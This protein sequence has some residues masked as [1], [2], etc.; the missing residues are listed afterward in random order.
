RRALAD[1]GV[2]LDVA[3]GREDFRFPASRRVL[4]LAPSKPDVLHL[5]NLHGGYF[6]LRILPD[7]AE[8]VP[9]VVTMHDEWLFTGHC[10]YTLGCE[11]WLTACGE[12]PHLDV[13]PALRVDGTAGNRGRKAELYARARVH[14]AAPSAWLLERAQRSILAPAIASA[15]V[16]PNGV[17]L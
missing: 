4:E 17:D 5:H 13:Y 6:D 14:V 8:R 11:R 15:R 9:T 3:R 10:A 12:C 1:P 7:V 2:A 16:V